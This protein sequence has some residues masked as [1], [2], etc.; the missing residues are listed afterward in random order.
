MHSRKIY[1]DCKNPETLGIC[2]ETSDMMSGVSGYVTG[3]SGPSS[4]N[5]ENNKS[6]QF[7]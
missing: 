6:S 7:K 5:T 4:Q 1:V 2:P 3:V